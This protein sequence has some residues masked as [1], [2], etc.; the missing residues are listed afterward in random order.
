MAMQI[1]TALARTVALLAEGVDRNHSTKRHSRFSQVVLLAEG[2]DRNFKRLG[3]RLDAHASPSSQ[4]VRI[5]IS[6]ISMALI[7]CPVA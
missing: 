5:E 3:K 1:S 2:V 4:R 6:A 7:T